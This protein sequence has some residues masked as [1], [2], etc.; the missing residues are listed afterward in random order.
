MMHI[1][2]ESIIK[3]AIKTF[4]RHAASE[5]SKVIPML[6]IRQAQKAIVQFKGN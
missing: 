1:I 3:H 4:G 2:N 5:L 6:S